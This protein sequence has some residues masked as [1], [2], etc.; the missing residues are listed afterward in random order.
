MLILVCSGSKV[1][2]NGV[3]YPWFVPNFIEAAF[4]GLD[5][6]NAYDTVWYIV[7]GC[8]YTMSENTGYY[9]FDTFLDDQFLIV[10]SSYCLCAEIKE[11]DLGVYYHI[12]LILVYKPLSHLLVVVCI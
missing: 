11:G 1:R 9:T 8:C 5:G 3:A 7:P 2:L 6:W 12:F 4:K 10:S